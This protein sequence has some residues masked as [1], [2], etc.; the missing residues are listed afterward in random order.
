MNDRRTEEH[1]YKRI[2]RDILEGRIGSAVLLYGR[3]R[4]LVD[5]AQEKLM[6]RYVPLS[7]RPVD[8][9]RIDGAAAR[10]EDIISSCE[11]LPAASEKRIVAVD[12]FPALSGAKPKSFGENGEETLLRYLE[13][14]PESCLLIFT[15]ENVD[16]RKKLFKALNR[17]GIVYDFTSLDRSQLRAFI[18][19]RFKLAGK[20]ADPNAA[21]QI[22]EASG[23]FGRDSE[24]TLLHLEN[25]IRKIIAY[26]SDDVIR[27]TDVAQV[28]AASLDTDIFALVDAVSRGR[29]AE[30][31]ELLYSILAT[32]ESAYKILALLFS[33]F[34]LILSVRELQDA[35][36][37]PVQIKGI[38]Q[39]HEFRIIKAAEF[40]RR[41]SA[42]Q[43][44]DIL[45]KA[46]E[47]DRN[48]KT[49]LLRDSMALEMFIAAVREA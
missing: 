18:E 15:A 31:L 23:Y 35:R 49:G 28:M 45:R 47:I 1:A 46:C 9:V 36:K 10:P 48:I 32:G 14:L 8:F 41:F 43:L 39:V 29:K 6:D 33:Q 34:E 12:G 2:S 42:E 25:D 22:I 3:E 16:K 40:A 7:F 44:S 13:E 20:R 4:F 24:Y 11:T 5:W 37:T 38:L 21:R 17:K 27:L 26:S 30:A 19:K